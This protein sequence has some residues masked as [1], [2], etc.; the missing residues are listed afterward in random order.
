MQSI[1]GGFL[2]LKVGEKD[3]VTAE[4]GDV[5]ERRGWG[6][7]CREV[8]LRGGSGLDGVGLQLCRMTC[9]SLAKIW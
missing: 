6:L 2:N 1:P 3:R 7:A 5:H 8:D 4:E 9:Q